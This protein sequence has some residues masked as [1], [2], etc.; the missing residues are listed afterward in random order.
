MIIQPS[1]P[2]KPLNKL[3]AA[4][5]CELEAPI[6]NWLIFGSLENSDMDLG[7]C[8][9]FCRWNCK[10]KYVYCS[11]F[12]CQSW[13]VSRHV[14][15]VKCALE[16]GLFITGV[17]FLLVFSEG[18]HVWIGS[19]DD[20]SFVW[21]LWDIQNGSESQRSKVSGKALK[22]RA[23]WYEHV[24]FCPVGAPWSQIYPFSLYHK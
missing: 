20:M 12:T 19:F 18:C 10:D 4:W 15:W 8:F 2:M 3:F 7:G 9:W 23:W 22:F 21:C 11:C 24:D 1:F 17:R 14:Q 16:K 13:L 5:L 6:T